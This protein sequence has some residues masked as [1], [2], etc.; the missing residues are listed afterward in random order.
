MY[1]YMYIYIYIYI[2]EDPDFDYDHVPNRA[3]KFGG[4][5]GE[6]PK[7]GAEQAEWQYLSLS[8]SVYIYT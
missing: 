3:S 7:V 6:E 8:L 4:E 2:L 1:M 5:D